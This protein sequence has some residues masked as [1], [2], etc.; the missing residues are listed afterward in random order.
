MKLTHDVVTIDGK[1]LLPAGTALSDSVLD[2]LSSGKKASGVKTF[3]LMEHNNV[4]EN[5]LTFLCSYPYNNLFR[6]EDDISLLLDE[7]REVRLSIEVLESLDY[8]IARDPYSYRHFLLVFAVSTLLA[9]DLVPDKEARI[10]LTATGPAHDIGKTCVPIGVLKKVAPL[11][12]EEKGMIDNHSL[13]GYVLLGY[14]I[15]D[16]GHLAPIVARDHHERR[17]GSGKPS[18]KR[19]DNFM[20][21]II[22]ACDVYDALISPRPYRNEAYNNRSALEVLT[23]IGEKQQISLDIIRALI[24][25]NRKSKPDYRDFVLSSYKRGIEPKVNSYG[26]VQ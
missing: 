15:G 22:A 8:F 23:E 21:E 25:R 16:F 24:A 18:G 4:E 12:A 17:D 1:L 19:L 11:T 13:A 10:M 26:V 2:G 7:M 3:P 9:K 14:Y 20:T 6:E 5:L